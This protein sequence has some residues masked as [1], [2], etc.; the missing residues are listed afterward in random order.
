[1]APLFVCRVCGEWW[2][3]CVD[4]VCAVCRE[5]TSE[6]GAPP[7][8]SIPS[9]P[10]EAPRSRASSGEIERSDWAH[11]PRQP[12][13]TP[14]PASA[15][16][17][18]EADLESAAGAGPGEIRTAGSAGRSA[19]SPTNETGRVPTGVTVGVSPQWE[20]A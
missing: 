11:N 8:P 3:T 20:G 9:R 14:G 7:P 17:L 4:F 15:H 2:R 10:A 6:N 12:G 1:M 13:A 19:A 18:S 16:S 5:K